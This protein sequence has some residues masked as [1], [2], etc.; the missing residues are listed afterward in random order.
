[1][2]TITLQKEQLDKVLT[3][4]E[5]LIED[6]ASLIDQDEIVTK[7]IKDIEANPAIG[8]SEKELDAYLQKRGVRLG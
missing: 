2:E 5:V 8:K 6:V 3:D 4:V 7:R 1:M